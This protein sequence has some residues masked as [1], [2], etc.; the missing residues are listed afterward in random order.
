MNVWMERACIE[1]TH[2]L[3][4][5]PLIQYSLC[6]EVAFCKIPPNGSFA[7]NCSGK[8]CFKVTIIDVLNNFVFYIN[9]ENCSEGGLNN[10]MTKII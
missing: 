4:I 5:F 9:Y 1:L 3:L 10:R 6:I 8:F 2:W 7:F